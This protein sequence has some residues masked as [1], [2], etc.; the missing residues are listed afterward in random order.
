MYTE[1]TNVA[2]IVELLWKYSITSGTPG[3]NIDDAK[4]L[5]T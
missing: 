3:A 2:S 5:E 4:G 1:T